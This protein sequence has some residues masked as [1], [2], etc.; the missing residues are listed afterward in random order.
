MH[1]HELPRV[2]FFYG[3]EWDGIWRYFAFC[4]LLKLAFADMVAFS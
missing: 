4:M 3:G 2:L 1:V